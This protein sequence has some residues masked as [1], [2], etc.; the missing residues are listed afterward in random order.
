MSGAACGMV[1][2][3][4]AGTRKDYF[5]NSHMAGEIEEAKKSLKNA[6]KTDLEELKNEYNR[7]L[8]GTVNDLKERLDTARD[9]V[10][11]H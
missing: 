9:A 10:A 11:V 4:I 1:A 7:K 5:K 6:A 3:Y 2:G 8:T